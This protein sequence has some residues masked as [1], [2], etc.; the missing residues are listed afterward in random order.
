MSGIVRRSQ[1]PGGSFVFK[2]I[3]I[4]VDTAGTLVVLRKGEVR[5]VIAPQRGGKKAVCV[6]EM[7]MRYRVGVSLA[8]AA[9]ISASASAA[10]IQVGEFT[11][12][13]QET[14]E[15]QTPFQ[16]L[17]S[18][19][20]FD[21]QGVVEVYG[22]GQGLHVTTSWGYYYT[23]YPHGGSYFMGGASATAQWVFDTPALKFGGFFGTNYSTADF[24]AY[25]FDEEGELL[26]ELGGAA[27]LGDWKWNGWETDGAGIK[28]VRIV[29]A[30]SS[31]GFVMMDDMQY[32]PIP[33]PAA[34]S[35]LALALIGRRRR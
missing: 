9:T 31:G 13:Y 21:D 14:M 10:I 19:D 30:H 28:T 24:T 7:K 25:L 35:L 29:G 33:A 1:F 22:G 6:E 12:D 23:I 27:P 11:G 16:F 32:T 4:Y 3:L 15:T 34:L 8:V 17:P 20:V 18:Y 5:C 26:A 2:I